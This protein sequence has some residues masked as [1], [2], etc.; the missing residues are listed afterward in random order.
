MNEKERIAFH[1]VLSD[2][3]G[4]TIIRWLLN[5]CGVDVIHGISF[6]GT[7]TAHELGLD[8]LQAIMYNEIDKLKLIISEQETLEVK[9]GRG[10]RESDNDRND[11]YDGDSVYGNDRARD[12]SNY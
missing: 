9:N 1:N 3:D 4:R 8:L 10:N 11:G 12:D 7:R 6:R 5:E 2:R